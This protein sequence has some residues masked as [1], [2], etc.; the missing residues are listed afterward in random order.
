M[1]KVKVHNGTNAT[2]QVPAR[3]YDRVKKLPVETSFPVLPKTTVTL[4][5]LHIYTERLP[6]GMSLH[7]QEKPQTPAQQPSTV[8]QQR[9]APQTLAGVVAENAT[10]KG[11]KA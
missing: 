7:W 11:G 9:Q 8:P 5:A 10:K 3:V 2:L 6:A 1:H 4:E